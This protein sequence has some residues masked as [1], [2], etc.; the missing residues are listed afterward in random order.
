MTFVFIVQLFMKKWLMFYEEILTS[1][2]ISDADQKNR[3]D[4]GNR[5]KISKVKKSNIHT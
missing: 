5:E 4:F 1:D 3:M 2:L